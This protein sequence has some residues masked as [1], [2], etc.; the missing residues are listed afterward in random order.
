MDLIFRNFL[1]LLFGLQLLFTIPVHGQ[2]IELRGFVLNYETRDPVENA[3]I[4]IN[5]RDIGT[6]TD[7]D[8]F[9]MLRLPDS[10]QS[11]T[12][13]ISYLGFLDYKLSIKDHVKN[14]VFLLRPDILQLEKSIRVTADKLDL[15]R[16]EMPHASYTMDIED[17]QRLGSSEISDVFKAIPSVRIEG[18]DLDGRTIQIRGSNP[19]E[20]NVYIDGVLINNLRFDH[21][22]DLSM[23]STENIEKLEVLKGGNLM[24]LG[25]GAF[26]GVVNIKTQKS[27]EPA[28]SIKLKGG[29][30]K[31]RFGHA[32]LNVP[33]SEK[34]I[35][36]YF[37][38][39]NFT[40][41]EIEFFP[42]EKYA[43][44]TLNT[45]IQSKKQNHHL[46]ANIVLDDGNFDTKA[47]AYL[48]DYKKP[49]WENRYDNYVLAGNYKGDILDLSDLDLSV[50]Y[51]YGDNRVIRSESV[52][53]RYSSS[54]TSKRLNGRLAK[55][56]TFKNTDLQFLSEYFHDELISTSELFQ[57]TVSRTVYRGE[58]YDNRLAFAGVL[59]FRDTLS[60]RKDVSWKTYLGMR[61]DVLANGR[62][63]FSHSFGVQFDIPAAQWLIRPYASYGKNVKYPTLLEN[64]FLQDL[65]DFLHEDSTG[66]RLE[67]EFNNSGEIGIRMVFTPEFAGYRS[68][69]IDFAWFSNVFYNK[70]L[71][72]PF[73]DLI[74]R[75]QIGRS[76]TK[77]IEASVKLN[78]L[79]DIFTIGLSAIKLDIADPYL[80]PYKPEENYSL[81]FDLESGFGFYLHSLSYYQ[82]KSNAWYYDQDDQFVTQT[83]EPFFDIDLSVGYRYP[84]GNLVLEL[85]MA[86]YNILDNS[87]YT[88]YTLNKRYLQAS[89]LVRY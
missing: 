80:Y 71:T 29:S 78:R 82:G 38:Q 59:A 7:A 43:V 36:G 42:G 56:F 19:D 65:T 45:H 53:S 68:L 26:G 57:N 33:L 10:F 28:Y 8:G 72:R 34:V 58:V 75:A 69:A 3:N 46:D 1:I 25:Q 30:F 20:V 55:S 83:L 11:D 32:S 4:Y 17:I 89:F 64:A 5:E 85:Q 52:S 2:S 48:L 24:L 9:F 67:P 40:E 31:T 16:R 77:G 49:G 23:V 39:I 73:D 88:Y 50:N 60:S 66:S 74:A 70:L 27:F 6:T 61:Y 15:A 41:P 13:V 62:Q 22:A 51:L 18:N 37:G 84:L 21:V 86:G 44:K 54:Y 81:Q 63:D 35:L 79:I 47:M 14:Q 12:L 76:T 87:G